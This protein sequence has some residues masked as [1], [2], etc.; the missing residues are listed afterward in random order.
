MKG[1]IWQ[2]IVVASGV[3]VRVRLG[4]GVYVIVDFGQMC[5]EGEANVL[6]CDVAA[7][8]TSGRR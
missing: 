3:K 2:F 7:D 6:T 4:A 5:G 8:D 1:M